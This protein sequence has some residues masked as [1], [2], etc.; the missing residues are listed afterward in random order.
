MTGSETVTFNGIPSKGQWTPPNAFLFRKRLPL[1]L[2]DHLFMLSTMLDQVLWDLSLQICRSMT[3]NH[4]T[5][6]HQYHWLFSKAL[7]QG[8]H[9]HFINT[10]KRMCIEQ[11]LEEAERKEKT[12][13]KSTYVPGMVESHPG[14]TSHS[15]SHRNKPWLAFSM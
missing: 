1:F 9:V 10:I 4:N 3:R 6:I 14:F 13:L 11:R 15:R 8:L 7:E 12:E 5:F 2:Q